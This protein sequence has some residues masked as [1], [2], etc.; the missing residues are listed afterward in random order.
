MAWGRAFM[1]N[2]CIE[3]HIFQGGSITAHLYVDDELH[4]PVRLFRDSV[5]Q[6][7]SLNYTNTRRKSSVCSVRIILANIR[8]H[9]NGLVLYSPD[10]NPIEYVWEALWRGISA[11]QIPSRTLQELKSVLLEEWR[12]I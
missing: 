7:C 2:G 4:S 12:A 5:G 11:R 1:T 6:D 3:M 10:L 8:Y 9:M